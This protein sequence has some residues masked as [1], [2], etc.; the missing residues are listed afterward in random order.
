M[1]SHVLLAGIVSSS[2]GTSEL[3]LLLWDLQ[4]GVLLAS[5]LFALPQSIP[6]QRKQGIALS[7]SGP[8]AHVSQVLLTLVLTLA[9]SV[10]FTMTTTPAR[11]LQPK[12]ST[13]RTY[14]R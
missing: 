11:S 5:H 14:Q 7:L 10:P 4:Y 2:S 13:S 3:A 6:R 9:A 1:S 12:S 8:S